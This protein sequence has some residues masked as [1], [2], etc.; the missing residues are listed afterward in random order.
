MTE[1]PGN[2]T[3]V[4]TPPQGVD[5]EAAKAHMADV[6][7]LSDEKIDFMLQG[8]KKSMTQEFERAENALDDNNLEQFS[9]ASH[10][11]KGAL[12]NIGSKEW[13]DYA[14]MLELSAKAEAHKDYEAL[15]STF[16]NGLKVLLV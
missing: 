12:L 10:T 6:Y 9:R 2:H 1:Q 13:A 14:R 8:L 7:K 16:K 11:I 3:N 15:L 5:I 4:T